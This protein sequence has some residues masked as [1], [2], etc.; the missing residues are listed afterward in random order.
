MQ[1]IEKAMK[2]VPPEE[3]TR[4][5][6]HYGLPRKRAKTVP[7]AHG[8]ASG[9]ACSAA[10]RKEPAPRLRACPAGAAS[11]R[12]VIGCGGHPGTWRSTGIPPL[13]LPR[14]EMAQAPTAM[15]IFGAGTAS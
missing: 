2:L 11:R 1:L 7:L 9:P 4:L 10:P 13:P 3:L 5:F 15:T 12:G 8:R 14:A 6:E